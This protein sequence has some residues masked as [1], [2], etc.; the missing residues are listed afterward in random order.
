MPPA[1]VSALAGVN[2]DFKLTSAA[3]DAER[4]KAAANWMTNPANP[5]FS[6]VIVNRIW[7]HHFGQ[8]LVK[9][10]VTSARVVDGPVTPSC[11]TGSPAGFSKTITA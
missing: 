4:R 8:G 5:L 9:N 6:R 11:S 10:Q 2:P 7:H 1:G 3:S